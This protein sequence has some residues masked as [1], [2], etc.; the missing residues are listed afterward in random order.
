MAFLITRDFFAEAAE[1]EV[2]SRA[3]VIGPSGTSLTR[4][5]IR[6]VGKRFRMYDAD[7]ELYMEGKHVGEDLFEPLDGLGAPD[8]GCTE[9]RY[10]ENG[11]WKPL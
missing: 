5:A 2:P 6:M 3:G 10:L 1:G 7:G 11:L 9:I 8:A 4:D